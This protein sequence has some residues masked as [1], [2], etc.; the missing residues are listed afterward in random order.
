MKSIVHA[1]AKTNGTEDDKA[2]ADESMGVQSERDSIN[3]SKSDS[4]DEQQV[5]SGYGNSFWRNLLENV[6]DQMEQ[7]PSN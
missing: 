4:E 2:S 7:L 5:D 6:F 1:D 3:E